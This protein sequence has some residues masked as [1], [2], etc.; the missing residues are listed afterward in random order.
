[1]PVK[2]RLKKGDRVVVLSGKHAGERGNIIKVDREKGR[3]VV[4]GVN[5]VKKH[6]RA[7]GRIR[8]GG[9]VDVPQPIPVARVMRICPRCDKPTPLRRIVKEKSFVFLCKNCEEEFR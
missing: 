9:I 7:Q 3:V 4:E 2:I 1:M 5:L 6:T 8:Q